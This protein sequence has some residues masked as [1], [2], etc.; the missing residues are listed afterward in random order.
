MPQLY[1]FVHNLAAQASLLNK[2]I[3]IPHM[4]A[5]TPTST[6]IPEEHP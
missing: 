4:K 6:Q 3:T 1:I 5:C 2:S